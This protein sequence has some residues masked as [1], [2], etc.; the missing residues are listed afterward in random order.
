M[1]HPFVFEDFLDDTHNCTRKYFSHPVNY[2]IKWGDVQSSLKYS[3]GQNERA[4]LWIYYFL[5]YLPS[6]C[7][8]L[9]H[10]TF[11][12]T[13]LDNRDEGIISTEQCLADIE[14]HTRHIRNDDMKKGGWVAGRDYHH[15]YRKAY[16]LFLSAFKTEA[17]NRLCSMLGYEPAM[18][19][20]LGAE[21][22]LR[23]LFET[24]EYEPGLPYGPYDFKAAT[25]VRY[26]EK[27]YRDDEK[28]ADESEL[29]PQ[30]L[31]LKPPIFDGN[32]KKPDTHSL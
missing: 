12:Q 4:I 7:M 27:Y 26:R 29:A 8:Y 15:T 11:I 22:H 9:P 17:R 28:Q 18:K 6:L 23:Q 13:L 32:E 31:G 25:I 1:Q 10:I 19:F 16:K 20:S 3:P 30:S 2:S 21:L 5:G 24:E 14:V